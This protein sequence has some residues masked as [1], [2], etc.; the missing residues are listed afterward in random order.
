HVLRRLLPA[1]VVLAFLAPATSASADPGFACRGT[2]LRLELA[3]NPQTLFTAGG[4]VPCQA[5]SSAL[6]AAAGPN[7][8]LA[9][10]VLRADAATPST[11]SA[12][13]SGLHL[14]SVSLRADEVNATATARCVN[15]QPVLEGSANASGLSVAGLNI[16]GDDVSETVQDVASGLP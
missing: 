16:D 1:L 8:G 2:A 7:L 4:G 14:A 3:G 11:A 12:R 6:T 5:D 9:A 10:N 13:V 15:G